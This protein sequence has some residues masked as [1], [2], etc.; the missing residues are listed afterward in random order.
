MSKKKTVDHGWADG[1]YIGFDCPGCGA[2]LVLTDDNYC[3]SG[4]D[5]VCS[6]G[7][8]FNGKWDVEVWEV[9]DEKVD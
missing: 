6:C 1:G 7:K 2:D 9:E 3:F 4:S 8:K 5:V